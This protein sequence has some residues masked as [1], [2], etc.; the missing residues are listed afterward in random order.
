M[1]THVPPSAEPRSWPNAVVGRREVGRRTPGLRSIGLLAKSRLI[2]VAGVRDG[3][4]L[5]AN[6]AF[7]A[8]FGATGTLAGVMLGD[9]AEDSFGDRLSASLAAA[10]RGPVSYLGSGKGADGRTFALEMA[11]EC[12]E[13]DNEP[14]I[15]AFAW[16]ITKRMRSTRLL[17]YLAYTDSLTGLANRVRFIHTVRRA[18]RPSPG[19]GKVALLMLDLDGFKAINDEYGHDAGDAVLQIAAQRLR[20]C[21]REED[22]AARLGGDEFAVLLPRLGAEEFAALVALRVIG[23]FAAPLNLGAHEVYLGASIGI[24]AFPS[25]ARSAEALVVAADAA[26]Y[27]AKRAGKGRYAWATEPSPEALPFAPL[28]WSSAHALGIPVIDDQH[29]HLAELIDELACTLRSKDAHNLAQS[30]LDAVIRYAKVHFA[31]E[32]RIMR[33]EHIDDSCSTGRNTSA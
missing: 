14:T 5:F 30:R 9:L 1:S 7:E 4:V 3:R 29:A 22:T 10:E 6:L 28:L 32:E 12:L 25:H 8:L 18:L 2:A 31:T 23:A 26:L 17:S 20:S 21:L 11:L 13:V 33:D 19:D 16:D 24:A 27:A 15:V